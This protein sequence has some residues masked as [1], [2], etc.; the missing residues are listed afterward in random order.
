MIIGAALFALSISFAGCGGSTPPP[1]PPPPAPEPTPPPAPTAEA[2]VEPPPPETPKEEPPPP[3]K[4]AKD[5]LLG[6]GWDFVL[7]FAQSDVKAKAEEDCKKKAKEDEKKLA[8]CMS[9]AE[10]DAAND[11]IKFAKDDKD[12]WWFV[13]LGKQKGKEVIYTKVQVKLASEEPGKLTF[14]PEGKDTG[15]KPIKKLPTELA[16]EMPDEYQVVF[17]HPDHGKLVYRVKVTGDSAPK[18]IEEPK[19]EEKK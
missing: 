10:A 9:K 15:K 19:L 1:E 4:A 12:N 8:D 17:N 14:T 5:V 7:D 18:P 11:R 2:P 16:F 3:R 13:S 6:E